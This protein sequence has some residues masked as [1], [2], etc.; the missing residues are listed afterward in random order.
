MSV[1]CERAG[2]FIINSLLLISCFPYYLIHVFMITQL[3]LCYNAV[4]E[5]LTEHMFPIYK[6]S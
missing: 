1:I 4:H 5:C 2:D 6:L 3:S